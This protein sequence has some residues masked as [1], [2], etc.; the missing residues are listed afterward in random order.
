MKSVY[1]SVLFSFFCFM[2]NGQGSLPYVFTV[3]T[4]TY[5]ELENPTSLT[6]NQ[7]WD[8]PALTVPI[9]FD[10]HFFGDTITS[11]NATE[12]LLGGMLIGGLG[13]NGKI[14]MVMPYLT[15]VI[16]LGF[17]SGKSMSSINYEVTGESPNRILK[18]EWDNVGFYE[19]VDSNLPI[20]S[21][22]NFQAWFHEGTNDIE[23]RFGP[24][25]IANVEFHDYGGFTCGFAENVEFTTGVAELVWSMTGT[26]DNPVMAEQAGLFFG[27]DE[28]LVVSGD[29]SD[30]TVYR[31]GSMITSTHQIVKTLDGVNVYPTITQDVLNIKNEELKELSYKIVNAQG[32]LIR[33]GQSSL[34]DQS[35][36]VANLSTGNYF[37]ILQEDERMMTSKFLVIQ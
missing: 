6:F 19:E 7:V 31:F 26:I 33:E 2:A 23:Y 36:N 35:I 9:P 10:F 5:Q 22:I 21:F 24:S 32:M 4:A 20:E 25:N 17:R 13:N 30:G 8:D 12:D 29:P 27:D 11:L 37:I 16:D 28:P 34:F 18:I 14:D 3:E 15:D 1:Y